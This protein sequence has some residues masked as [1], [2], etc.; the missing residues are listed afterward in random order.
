MSAQEENRQRELAVASDS[1]PGFRDQKHGDH[2]A[3][4]QD[5]ADSQ[6]RQR[7]GWKRRQKETGIDLDTLTLAQEPKYRYAELHDAQHGAHDRGKARS[8]IGSAQP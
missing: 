2:R 1:S 4:P 7:Q 8:R 6:N 5:E 3:E